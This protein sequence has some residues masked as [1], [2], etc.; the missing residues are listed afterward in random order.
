M[1]TKT[2]AKKPTTFVGE[3]SK[4]CHVSKVSMKARSIQMH[5]TIMSPAPDTSVPYGQREADGPGHSGGREGETW[6]CYLTQWAN[7]N[8]LSPMTGLLLSERA[9]KNVILTFICPQVVL[10]CDAKS[11]WS[12]FF[13]RYL[14]WGWNF[15]SQR[16]S[17]LHCTCLLLILDA[18]YSYLF[19]CLKF[20]KWLVWTR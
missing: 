6:D 14:F 13:C 16:S 15:D 5:K 20:R 8:R 17:G 2:K 9:D 19:I 4:E 7:T 10:T 3:Y 12:F 18:S 1:K 11:K